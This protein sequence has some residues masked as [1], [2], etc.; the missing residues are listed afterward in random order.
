MKGMTLRA[1]IAL[2][3]VAVVTG[4]LT[5]FG[6]GA[7]WSLQRELLENLDRQIR[8]GAAAFAAELEEQRVDWNRR[9]KTESFSEEDLPRFPYVEVKDARQHLLYRSPALGGAEIFPTS[10][11]NR[12]YE[13]RANGRRIRFALFHRN[14]VTFAL[15]KD[16]QSVDEA[17]AGLLRAYLL[18]LPLVALVVGAGGWWVAHRAVAPVRTIAAQAEKISASDLDQRLPE[19]AA[20]DE[21]S[22]LTRVLNQMFHRLE[23]SFAQ[24][25]RFTSDASH[26][27]KTPLTLLRAEAESVLASPSAGEA[28]QE[29]AADVIAQ[30]SR[31]T[32]IV[33]GLLF[34]S[35]A[36]DRRLDLECTP[37]DLAALVRELTEDAE[38]MAAEAKLTLR[39]ELAEDVIAPGDA[40]LLR[41]SVMNLIDNAIKYNRPGGTVILSAARENGNAVVSVRN[42]GPGLAEESREQV[43][44]RFYRG[45]LSH[46]RE[47]PGHGLGL[48]IAREVA[49]AHGGDVVLGE[50]NAE[51]TEFSLRLPLAPASP[52]EISSS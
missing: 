10:H 42:T 7:A 44:D 20:E 51:W 25:T 52:N 28:E 26:E 21:I 47:P 43:F 34:L 18:T 41:R 2:W 49:R 29:L 24:V 3:S 12:P 8:D 32:Q 31:L 39:S 27:L 23:R 4:A 30:C 22:H 48:S 19:P 9:Q 40:P 16:L 38:I 17:L 33:D 13:V 1:R 46:H 5:L 14:G 36:E 50:S 15:G 37:V 35:R 11:P 45:D 6:A